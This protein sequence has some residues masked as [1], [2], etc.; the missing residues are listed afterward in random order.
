MIPSLPFV[1]FA[2]ITIE[3]TTP[4][5]IGV[6]RGDG[7]QDA[8]F[9][10]DA[11]GLPALPGSSLA[12]VLRHLS[13]DFWGQKK[14]GQLFGFVEDDGQSSR[15]EVSWGHIHSGK[16]VPVCGL[17]GEDV[18]QEDEILKALTERPLPIREGV[19]INGRGVAED[20]GKFDRSYLAPGY[21]FS[22]DLLLWDEESS[23]DWKILLELI[24][25]PFF[26]LGGMT[27]RG[28]GAFKMVRLV[29]GN[30]DLRNSDDL[31]RYSQISSRNAIKY[32]L[33]ICEFLPIHA[34]K[35][36]SDNFISF[37]APSSFH[38]KCL[39]ETPR[40]CHEIEIVLTPEPGGFLFGAGSIPMG[41]SPGKVADSLPLSEVH[42]TWEETGAVILPRR[43]IVIPASSVKGALAHRVA[44]HHNR[45][46]GRFDN[47]ALDA[48]DNPAVHELF[49]VAKNMEKASQPGRVWLDDIYLSVDGTK[50]KKQIHNSIDR[51]TGGVIKGA[52]FSEEIVHDQR[53]FTMKCRIADKKYGNNVLEAL[54][55]SL[56]DLVQGRLALG[57]G[58]SRGHG[59]FQGTVNWPEALYEG[60]GNS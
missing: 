15:L 37:Q 4:L 58:A 22:F 50:L 38:S 59:Y 40:V 33:E 55:C 9:V 7:L 49:G 42:I 32:P 48:E 14:T 60:K 34:S 47:H 36:L 51:F 16:D 31:D 39:Q 24:N 19:R 8:L 6:G 54:K 57:A 18:L 12:G 3:N 43:D 27:H 13:E 17:L 52:L 44:Y 53:T 28:F 5:S 45:L 30:F 11:N 26:R 29:G 46:E 1:H 20:S 2:R 10:L 56:Q 25:S 21:R 35:N 23:P 41:S